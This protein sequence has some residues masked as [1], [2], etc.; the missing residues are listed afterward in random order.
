MPQDKHQQIKERFSDAL[1]FMR[2]Q[3]ARMKEDFKFSNPADPQQWDDADLRKRKG[4]PCFTFDRTNQFI[5]QV[6]NDARQNKPSVQILPVDSRGDKW[7][8]QVIGG[9]LK[10]IEYQSRADHAY[11]LAIEHTARGGLGWI[12][13]IPEVM[14]PETNEQEVRIM[15][16]YDPMSCLLDPNST[17][18]DGQDARH[19]FVTTKLTK[20]AFE[21]M[22]PKAKLD[23]WEDD[24]AMVWHSDDTITVCEYFDIEDKEETRL[25]VALPDGGEREISEDEYWKLAE[26]IGTNPVVLSAK[27]VVTRAQTWSKATGC[28]ILEETEFPCRWV[29]L[30]PVYGDEV[31]VDG[32]RYL[33]GLVRKLRPGQVAYNIE[34]SAALEYVESQPKAPFMV[35]FEAVEGHENHWER[36]NG[37]INPAW[38]P[39]N[40]MDEQGR[41]IPSPSR[42]SPPPF[43]AA[44]AQLGQIA[45][46][47]MEAAVGMFKANL[48]VS[49]NETSGRAIQARK[50]EGDTAT[51]HYADNLMRSIAQVGRII[52]DMLPKL[53][54]EKRVARIIGEDGK[55]D[56]VSVVPGAQTVRDPQT[57]KVTQISIEAG[58]YDVRVVA[59]ASYTTQRQEA[60][61]GIEMIL[62]AVPQ[63]SPALVPALMKLRD[64]PDAEK[65]SRMVM[66][67]AP[68]QIQQIAEGD[69]DGPPPIPA[70]AQN[71]INQLQQQ[72][73]QMQA[74]MQAA[75]KGMQ[76]L[77]E[78]AAALE[79]ENQA[80]KADKSIEAVTAQADAQLKS[81][82]AAKTQ[83]EAFMLVNGPQEQPEAPEAE[84][85]AESEPRMAP[86]QIVMPQPEGADVVLS[87]V[88]Q[89]VEA[90][91]QAQGQIASL[92]SAVAQSVTSGQDEIR[93]ALTAVAE[94]ALAPRE[95][96]V[97]H[98][99][100]GRASKAV[101]VPMQ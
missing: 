97:F 82:Q 11:D 64:F 91:A 34:R 63:L 78:K 29:P 40:S 70:V 6:V 81:A 71:Q 53:Y 74:M 58:A 83:A 60:A 41:P 66:A 68:P 77:D 7:A 87:Q 47:D 30:V 12:R 26:Q 85:E 1:E 98:D 10:H 27:K 5:N 75:D 2:D 16:V 92:V 89:A 90:M 84:T 4:R 24:S 72:L 36:M 18:P 37:P 96:E 32:K 9:M 50:M 69:D 55:Q 45:S 44:F 86:V 49:G 76:E 23:T 13:V 95:I 43:P 17:E 100:N 3:H 99:K 61:Q 94:A 42:M 93:Q 21:R 20:R 51:F 52:V 19:G 65:Y 39:Y 28:E 48:G 25:T 79:M 88:S 35:P 14:R 57:R 22:Y 80:L 38:L 46:Q 54:D 31:W 67:M 33:G 56:F 15:R 73:Q 62:Q 8:A 59:G 101:S